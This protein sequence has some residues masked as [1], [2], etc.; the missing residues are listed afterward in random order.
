[1]NKKYFRWQDNVMLILMICLFIAML[2]L[3]IIEN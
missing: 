1:M 3:K 2:T